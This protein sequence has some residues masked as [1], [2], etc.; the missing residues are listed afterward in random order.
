MWFDQIR[1][2]KVEK[3]N[4]LNKMTYLKKYINLIF[5]VIATYIFI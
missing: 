4:L 5:F 1:K 2:K 3:E